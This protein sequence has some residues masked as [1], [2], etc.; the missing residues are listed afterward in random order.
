MALRQASGELCGSRRAAAGTGRAD[1]DPRLQVPRSFLSTL[2]AGLFAPAMTGLKARSSRRPS[3]PRHG[4]PSG[5][6]NVAP[7]Q[8]IHPTLESRRGRREPAQVRSSWLA[9]RG[10]ARLASSFTMSAGRASVT[11]RSLRECVTSD[12]TSASGCTQRVL[13][14][15]R[16]CFTR[17]GGDSSS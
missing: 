2:E 4:I 17:A 3:A 10:L 8:L 12:L 13:A 15:D 9:V 7:G 14:Q 16:G 11:T 1:C 5:A 6:V